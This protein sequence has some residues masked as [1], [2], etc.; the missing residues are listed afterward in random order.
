M[1]NH[2]T[3]KIR[4]KVAERG[5]VTIPKRLRD[6][7]GVRPGTILEFSEEAGRLIAAKVPGAD[8]VAE[9]YGCL[10]NGFDTD[11][12][13]AEIR[14]TL[15]GRVRRIGRWPNER[16]C[17]PRDRRGGTPFYSVGGFL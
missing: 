8:P 11:A 9:V 5:Q 1:K 14:S 6:R 13:L 17:A 7:L 2:G 15:P 4:A 10:G 12:F 3:K 16:A